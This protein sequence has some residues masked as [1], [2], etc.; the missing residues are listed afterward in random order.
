VY[1]KLNGEGLDRCPV[2]K[3]N[4]GRTPVEKLRYF[5][6]D[7]SFKEFVSSVIFFFHAAMICHV[8][9]FDK[10]MSETICRS[11]TI[12]IDALVQIG[13]MATGHKPL[14]PRAS[15]LSLLWSV[16]VTGTVTIVI[17]R[18]CGL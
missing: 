10:N 3:I 12:V 4:L 18:Y 8:F 14:W 9:P 15:G 2:C 13:T 11:Q 16:A 17:H 5:S 1:Q 7:L 6:C